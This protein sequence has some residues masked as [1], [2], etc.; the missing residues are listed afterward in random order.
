M[1][2]PKVVHR[3]TSMIIEVALQIKTVTSTHRLYQ[4]KKEY[5]DR[6]SSH[7]LTKNTMN[8]CTKKVGFVTRSFA[9][10]ASTK[11]CNIELGIKGGIEDNLL[12]IKREY[13]RKR[14]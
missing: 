7:V 13:C 3:K 14:H 6:F 11:H 4:L 12:E 5:C 8:A 9:K 1:I 10:L 2:D